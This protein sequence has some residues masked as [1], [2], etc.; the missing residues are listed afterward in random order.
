[1][2][3]HSLSGTIHRPHAPDIYYIGPDLS[4][5]PLPAVF[6]FSLSGSESLILDPYNQP[7][8][9]L[10][11]QGIRVF[12]LTLPAHEG[13]HPHPD[14]IPAWASSVASGTDFISEFAA[15]CT[16][17]LDYLVEMNYVTER[18]IAAAGLSRGAF[19]AAHFAAHDSRVKYLLGFSPLTRL[20]ALKEFHEVADSQL[21]QKLSLESISGQL[22]DKTVRFHIGNRDTCVGT[23]DCF[24]FIQALTEAAYEKKHRS[25]PIELII[26]PS[27]GHK[28]HGTPSHIFVAGADWLVSTFNIGV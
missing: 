10:S 27:I 18:R 4:L 12:S 1:M 24:S 11:R 28:G 9:A 5:G 21:S 20:G 19:A 16:H 8:V 26:Y 15:Q 23:A 3:H 17:A 22:A 6:Y 13:K 25:P 14:S 2:A 7:A